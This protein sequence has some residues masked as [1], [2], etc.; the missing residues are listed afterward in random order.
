MN[1][2][3][4]KTNTYK[5]NCYLDKTNQVRGL[6]EKYAVPGSVVEVR[7]HGSLLKDDVRVTVMFKSKDSEPVIYKAVLEMFRNYDI[8][9]NKQTISIYKE[10]GLI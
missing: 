8:K 5:I 4:N 1:I 7:S 6:A 2:F 9:I 3:K 10:T